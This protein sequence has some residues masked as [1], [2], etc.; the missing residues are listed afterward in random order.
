VKTH[1]APSLS[2]YASLSPARRRLVDV[3]RDLHFGRIEGLAIAGGEPQFDPPHT[4][5]TIVRTIRLPA[6]TESPEPSRSDFPLKRPILDLLLQF[7]RHQAG[8][9]LRL[10]C[11]H[12][13]PC[14]VE[15]VAGSAANAG[16]TQEPPPLQQ[17]FS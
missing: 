14:L 11:R 16:P 6:E 4:P 15:F 1:S 10:E 9:I 8:V 12:G 17:R 5:P 3:L 13:L 2:Y 7:D